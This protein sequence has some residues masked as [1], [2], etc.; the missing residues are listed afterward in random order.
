MC[1]HLGQHEKEVFDLMGIFA[2]KHKVLTYIH[3]HIHKHHTYIHIPTLRTPLSHL[4]THTQNTHTHKIHTKH[5][6]QSPK[7]HTHTHFTGRVCV[8]LTELIRAMNVCA[9]V[10]KS[11]NHGEFTFYDGNLEHCLPCN[12]MNIGAHTQTH[13]YTH[14]NTHERKSTYM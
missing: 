8:Q 5:T 6:A 12:P 10:E 2:Q 9:R 14:T 1:L 13:T 4:H 7:V 11:A 3:I